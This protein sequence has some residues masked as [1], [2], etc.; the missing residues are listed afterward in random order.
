MMMDFIKKLA[1]KKTESDCCRIE[2]T[3]V[4]EEEEGQTSCC[5][6]QGEHDTCCA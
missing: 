2:I 3:E 1:G 6:S 5:E 4:K